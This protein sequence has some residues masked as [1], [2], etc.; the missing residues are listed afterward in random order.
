MPKSL[1][2]E[3]DVEIKSLVSQEKGI[4]NLNI[5]RKLLGERDETI[6]HFFDKDD[7]H[8]TKSGIKKIFDKRKDEIF[9]M[10]KYDEF[11]SYYLKLLPN[12]EHLTKSDIWET[13]KRLEEKAGDLEWKNEE[14]KVDFKTMFDL[15]KAQ[16]EIGDVV[17]GILSEDGKNGSLKKSL[18]EWEQLQMISWCIIDYSVAWQG[19]NGIQQ[20]MWKI[21]ASFA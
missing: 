15:K 21:L 19:T 9:V 16:M 1:S 10:D 14:E 20:F 7:Q 11:V 3:E 8:F 18:K 2:T 4:E 6:K 12:H 17:S 5:I 13:R